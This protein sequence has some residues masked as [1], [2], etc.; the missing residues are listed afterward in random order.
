MHARKSGLS[1]ISSSLSH[2]FSQSFSFLRQQPYACSPSSL[3][4][5]NSVL[6]AF[7]CT[8]E[9]TQVKSE[10][11]EDLNRSSLGAPCKA[12][13]EGDRNNPFNNCLWDLEE[14]EQD[15]SHYMLKNVLNQDPFVESILHSQEDSHLTLPGWKC[16]WLPDETATMH[17]VTHGFFTIPG[18]S[19]GE[20]SQV[21]N[22]EIGF[23][24]E[25]TWGK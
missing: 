24:G 14:Q 25:K 7:F 6:L 4:W 3:R 23:L 11:E 20:R 8:A 18:I 13:R 15:S 9:K 16:K 19:R 5:Y 22:R 17:F 1:P 10:K 2:P 21:G 12:L